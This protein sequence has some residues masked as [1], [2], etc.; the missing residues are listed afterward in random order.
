MAIF[1]VTGL[2]NSGVG[3]RDDLL[4]AVTGRSMPDGKDNIHHVNLKKFLDTMY[5]KCSSFYMFCSI[6]LRIHC[7]S[8]EHIV[9]QC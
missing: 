3:S 7:P 8:F 2:Y 1:R 6:F 5:F 4:A 9:G